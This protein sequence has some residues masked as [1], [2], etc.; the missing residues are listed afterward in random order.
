TLER[1]VSWLFAANAVINWTLSVRGIVDPAGMATAFGGPVP[2]YPFMLR[3]WSAFVFMFG[4]M[5]WE[6]SRRPREKAAL[7]KYNWIEKTLTALAVTAG[8][9]MGEAPFRLMLLIVLTNWLWIPF[10]LWADLR[11]RAVRG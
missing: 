1:Q 3:L 11:M 7:L 5:F 8:Y 4:C 6:A 10:I 9:V 2:N